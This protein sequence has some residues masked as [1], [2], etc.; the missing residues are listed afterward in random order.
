MIQF[1]AR[2]L[3]RWYNK[4]AL[5][6]WLKFYIR[7]TQNRPKRGLASPYITFPFDANNVLCLSFY[8]KTFVTCKILLHL[9]PL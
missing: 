7:V 2:I 6:Y 4:N 5:K 9:V 3:C 1:F 8:F